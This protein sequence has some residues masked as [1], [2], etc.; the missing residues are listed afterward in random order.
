MTATPVIQ[1]VAGEAFDTTVHHANGCK[2]AE[3]Q[4]GGP[5]AAPQGSGI[6]TPL[7]P[8]N[9]TSIPSDPQAE[10]PRRLTRRLLDVLSKQFPIA[11]DG[12]SPPANTNSEGFQDPLL[13]IADMAKRGWDIQNSARPSPAGLPWSDLSSLELP[14]EDA[15]LLAKWSPVTLQEVIQEQTHYF[16]DGL[17]MSKRDVADVLDPIHRGIVDE[18]RAQELVQA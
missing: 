1:I 8:H 6:I 3:L 7:D 9:L 5:L 17:N 13:S 15:E 16:A 2:P 18:E 12:S 14:S 4:F 10:H 11:A